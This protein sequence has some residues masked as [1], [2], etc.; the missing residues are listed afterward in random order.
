[1]IL[2]PIGL[3]GC[4]HHGFE[5][6]VQHA[7]TQKFGNNV[8]HLR[9]ELQQICHLCCH[10]GCYTTFREECARFFSN[11]DTSKC[12]FYIDNSFPSGAFGYESRVP[13]NLWLISRI[14]EVL[15]KYDN[16]KLVHLK[17]NLLNTINSHCDWDGGVVEHARVLHSTNKFI[18]FELTTLL[19]KFPN[20]EL[21][22]VEYEKIG[23]YEAV[24]TISSITGVHEHDVQSAINYCFKQSSKTFEDAMTHDV[25]YSIQEIFKGKFDIDFVGVLKRWRKRWK[26]D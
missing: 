21:F 6:V 15:I 23:T 16:V 26:N 18:D 1:M 9:G 4:G 7:I 24:P 10:N 14:Y 2:F 13:G 22:E 8:Y 20:M 25:Q 17:R 5:P 19:D 3:E 12:I 11:V